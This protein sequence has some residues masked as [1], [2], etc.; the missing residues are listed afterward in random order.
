MMLRD[1]LNIGLLGEEVGMGYVSERSHPDDPTLRIYNYTKKA[2]AEGRWNDV[3]R[4]TRGLIVR[5]GEAGAEIV[6]RPFEKFFNLGEYIKIED[7]DLDQHVWA[8]DKVDGSLGILYPHPN[9]G[10]AIATRGSFESEQAIRGTEILRRYLE[11]G[12]NPHPD[13]TYLFEI[14]YPE[15]RIVVDYGDDEKLVL[16]STGATGGAVTILS[17]DGEDVLVD[18]LDAQGTPFP[19]PLV[20]SATLRNILALPPRPN[21]EGWVLHLTEPKAM[22]KVK[23]EDYIRLH[24]IVTGLNELTVW[25]WM[26]DH[27]YTHLELLDEIPEE[28]HGWTVEVAERLLGEYWKIRDDARGDFDKIADEVG[29]DPSA[30]DI[31]PRRAEFAKRAVG[32]RYQSLLFLMYDLKWGQLREAAWNMVRPKNAGQGAKRGLAA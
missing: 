19:K 23:Q 25:E 7:L 26:R 16:L 24:R 21:S 31:R 27:C 5:W 3:T 15:N 6:A 22:V 28:F 4:K 8:W 12:F 9:G 13:L 32:T 20:L 14:V 18:R 11:G 30:V 1:Y 10:Y 2:Q 29:Y 17:V